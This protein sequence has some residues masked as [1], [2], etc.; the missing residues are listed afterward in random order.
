MAFTELKEVVKRISSMQWL[1]VLI[2]DGAPNQHSIGI[3]HHDDQ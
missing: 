2:E 3:A 1:E